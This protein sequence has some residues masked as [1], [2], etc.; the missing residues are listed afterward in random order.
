MKAQAGDRIV[1]ERP[2]DDLPARKGV[3]LKVQGDNGGPPYW[4]RWEDEGRETLVYPGPD[5]RIEPR[6][7]VPQARQE[8]TEARQPQLGQSLKR[9]QIDVA[10]SEVHE[11]GSVR[12]LAEAQLPSTKW[13]LRGHGEARKHP[14]DADIPEIGEELAVA[15]ALSDLAHKLRRV[16]A[17]DIEQASQ[18]WQP[19]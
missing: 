13:N 6:H 3:V 4:V 8:H 10:V 19:T 15:R 16:A 12:T 5:A 18:A 11:N 14:T 7:P 1:V 17:E 2:R 9:I